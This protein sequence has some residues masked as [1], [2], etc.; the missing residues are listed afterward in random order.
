[1]LKS[2]Q[3]LEQ[4]LRETEL[5]KLLTLLVKAG[6][7]EQNAAITLCLEMAELARGLSMAQELRPYSD[8]P[9]LRYEEVASLL[10]GGGLLPR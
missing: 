8:A 7:V 4:V 6:A 9:A 10:S 1:M 3:A 2:Q 5:S